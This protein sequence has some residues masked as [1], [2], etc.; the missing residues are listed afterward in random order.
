MI[1]KLRPIREV[2]RVFWYNDSG[3]AILGGHPEWNFPPT[4]PS[5]LTVYMDDD[6]LIQFKHDFLG[7][8]FR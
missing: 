1:Y 2:C 6:Q 3:L 4:E 8:N 5:Y 7:V